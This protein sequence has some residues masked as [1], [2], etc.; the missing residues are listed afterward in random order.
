MPLGRHI[1][2]EIPLP[3]P[4]FVEEKDDGDDDDEEGGAKIGKEE[5]DEWGR[6]AAAGAATLSRHSGALLRA[7]A[8]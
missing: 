6:S 2:F 1:A 3:A 4:C 7:L 8:L 5:E